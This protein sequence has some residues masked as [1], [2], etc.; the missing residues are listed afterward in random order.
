[1][2]L[3]KPTS[4]LAEHGYHAL[5]REIGD[6]KPNRGWRGQLQWARQRAAL[7]RYVRNTCGECRTV[8]AWHRQLATMRS[9]YRRRR[10]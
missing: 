2:K 1:M 7:W 10:A 8:E 4:L 5:I 6:G 3:R 9:A